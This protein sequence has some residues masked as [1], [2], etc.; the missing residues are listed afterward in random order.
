MR[1]VVE[2][3]VAEALP[4]D[5]GRNLARTEAGDAGGPAVVPRD[6]VDLGID[7]GAG[8]FDDEVL[9]RIA[10]VDELGFHCGT[11]GNANAECWS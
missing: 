4:D 6:L 3:L 10:D 5:L 1:D 2:D 8:D 11:L 9:L 7:D